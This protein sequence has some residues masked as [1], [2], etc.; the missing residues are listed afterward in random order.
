VQVWL[1]GVQCLGA[2]EQSGGGECLVLVEEFVRTGTT[3]YQPGLLAPFSCC[4]AT[5]TSFRVRA[6]W[7]L[8]K[9]GKG[10]SKRVCFACEGLSFGGETLAQALELREGD[11]VRAIALLREVLSDPASTAEVVRLKEQAI[12]ALADLLL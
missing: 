7:V 1:L 10:L 9:G 6:P 4:A 3:G 2:E 12:V 8:L 5:A 11:P